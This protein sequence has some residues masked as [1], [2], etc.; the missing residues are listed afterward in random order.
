MDIIEGNNCAHN[1]SIELNIT[2]E[3]FK[4]YPSKMLDDSIYSKDGVIRSN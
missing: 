4:S 1:L 3:I 2:K